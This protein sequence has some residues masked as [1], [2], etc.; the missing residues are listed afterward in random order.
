ML[1]AFIKYLN[2]N[3]LTSS[4]HTLIGVSGGRDSVVLC[5]L[6]HRANLP[7][8]IAHCNFNLRADESDTDEAFVQALSVKY[9]VKLH[10]KQCLTKEYADEKGI[11]IQ[12]AA[13]D[14]RFDFFKGLLKK[15]KYVYYATAHHQD[16]AIETY[17]I[18]QIRGTGIAGLHGILPKVGSLIHPLLFASRQDIDKFIEKHHIEYRDD[19]TNASTKYMRNKI[20]HDLMPMFIDINPQ[21]REVFQ[22]NMKRLNAVEQIYNTKINDIKKEVL[23]VSEGKVK[24]RLDFDPN[25]G[26]TVL[27][28]MVKTYGFNFS[29]ASQIMNSL[30]KGNNGSVFMSITHRLLLD[31]GTLTIEENI[32]EFENGDNHIY[33]IDSSTLRID[34]PMEMRF[35]KT[36]Q[37]SII[38]DNHIAQFDY[39]KLDF[40]LVLRKW[41]RG[42]YFC[43]LGMNGKR[44]LI[45][46]FFIDEKIAVFQKEKIY[47]LCSGKHIIWVVG[48][49]IDDR[50]KI[51]KD[52][53]QVLK[54]S[55][56]SN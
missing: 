15:Y 42:D 41:R 31:R 8:A 27:Y 9:G 4:E 24:I 30:T 16:D 50:Y 51:K 5:E 6:Y 20:R 23:S 47:L 43:P 45:S 10:T 34:L 18:N 29:Q 55:L 28:E 2:E 46:D 36:E 14:L 32:S 13:R 52:S 48:H 7:F 12:M 49:R 19:S 21:I 22:D 37:N 11:S 53:T 40:P 33:S 56:N 39:S 44:K 25:I 54:V 38:Q 3:Y 17:L 1:T 35:E 26:P